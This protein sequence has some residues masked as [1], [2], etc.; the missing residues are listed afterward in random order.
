MFYSRDICVAPSCSLILWRVLTV[1]FHWLKFICIS[2]KLSRTI[3]FPSQP[4][5]IPVFTIK[6]SEDCFWSTRKI[7]CFSK[8][9]VWG[10]R[11][12]YGNMVFSLPLS[13]EKLANISSKYRIISWFSFLSF[14]KMYAFGAFLISLAGFLIFQTISQQKV[15]CK[16]LINIK[17]TCSTCFYIFTPSNFH[18]F[19]S[20][21]LHYFLFLPIP[22]D[23]I[24]S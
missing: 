5:V 3:A 14:F 16:L 9:Y 18:N 17:L 7:F 6:L 20:A 22:K 2:Q 4:T 12:N 11:H 1:L 10:M 19:S 21:N 8:F 24:F 13:T 23:R 15:I